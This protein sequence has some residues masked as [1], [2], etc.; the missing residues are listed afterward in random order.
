MLISRDVPVPGGPPCGISDLIDDIF[1]RQTRSNDTQPSSNSLTPATKTN[2]IFDLVPAMYHDD[3]ADSVSSHESAADSV[4]VSE[5]TNDSVFVPD[6]TT[7]SVLVPEPIANHVFIPEQ[8][9]DP[10]FVPDPALGQGA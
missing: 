2:I 3:E 1:D 9:A 6:S 10:V 7:D 5:S 4:F 8:V